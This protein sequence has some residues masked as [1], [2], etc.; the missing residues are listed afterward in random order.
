M[1]IARVTGSRLR[2]SPQG[3]QLFTDVLRQPVPADHRIAIFRRTALEFLET[4]AADALGLG[5]TESAAPRVAARRP[6]GIL[7]G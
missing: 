5:R 3:E 2:G 1:R 7:V 6:R 4:A